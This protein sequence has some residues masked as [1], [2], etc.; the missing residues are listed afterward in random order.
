MKN[1]G[2]GPI[3]QIRVSGG[4]AKSRLWRQII[5]DTL[6]AELVTVNT[7]EGAAFGAALLAGV[8]VGVWP[9]VDT[10]CAQTIV[11]RDPVSPDPENT[12]IYQSLHEQ[13]QQ[14]YPALKPTFEALG[15]D[16]QDF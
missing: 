15:Q 4:G 16:L 7:T 5:A 9:D 8:G 2:L 12:E 11:V 14:L 13:Y 6:G 1:V 3:E 10:A